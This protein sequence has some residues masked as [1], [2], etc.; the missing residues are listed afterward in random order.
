MDREHEDYCNNV[1]AISLADFEGRGM[2]DLHYVY[3]CRIK[4]YYFQNCSR[5]C[6]KTITLNNQKLL[7]QMLNLT[8]NLGEKKVLLPCILPSI[9]LLAYC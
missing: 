9:G 1:P 7:L 2:L 3:V 4:T 8:A 6:Y 5:I